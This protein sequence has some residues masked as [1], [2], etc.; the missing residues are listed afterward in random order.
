MTIK[1]LIVP[2]SIL[3][4]LN[5]CKLAAVNST[6][7]DNVVY[8]GGNTGD[9]TAA[10]AR[11]AGAQAVIQRNCVSCHAGLNFKSDTDAL[12]SGYIVAG[13]SSGSKLYSQMR[14]SGVAGGAQSMPPS[15]SLT[16]DELS[17]VRTWIDQMAPTS[18]VGDAASRTAAA[19]QVVS[20]AC[21][22][23]HQTT[24]TA[25]SSIYSGSTVAAFANFTTDS[26]F[27]QSGLVLPGYPA[28][29]WIYRAL[30]FH[31]DIGTMP[32]DGIAIPSSAADSLYNW[33]SKMGDP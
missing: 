13:N 7:Q 23:C 27:F 10:G 17:K 33:I 30:I 15:G 32:K 29:S 9:G 8:G 21:A 14:G 1:S 20:I 18:T 19:L 5:A 16:S 26:E 22:S 24:Q 31:G 4:L 12:Q 28:D 6:A 3:F 2:F 25:V 11:F